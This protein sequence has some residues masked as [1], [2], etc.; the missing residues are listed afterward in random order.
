[1]DE[2]FLAGNPETVRT[3]YGCLGGAALI[4]ALV[5]GFMLAVILSQLSRLRVLRA[6]EPGGDRHRRDH[7]GALHAAPNQERL[8]RGSRWRA[9]K[10]YLQNLEKYT[11]VEEATEIFERYLPY[12]VA[13]GLE[14]SFIRKFEKVNAPPPTWWI[15][16]GMPRPYYG[17]GGGAAGGGSG[18]VPRPRRT[19]AERGGLSAFP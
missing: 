13:F 9:F 18:H 6:A 19:D 2:G 5:G 1:M 12:A 4:I 8:G 16:Y 7:P 15:P 10:R 3:T 17:G 14:Q 11:K